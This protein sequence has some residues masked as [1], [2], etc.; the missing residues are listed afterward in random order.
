M[1]Q[2][3]ITTT[4]SL[5]RRKVIV[6][7]D[8]MSMDKEDY[9]LLQEIL[10]SSE[11]DCMDIIIRELDAIGYDVSVNYD[12]KSVSEGYIYASGSTMLLQAHY[13]TVRKDQVIKVKR[14]GNII[15]NPDGILGADDRAGVYAMLKIVKECHLRGI[16]KPGV[17][18]TGGEESGGIGMITFLEDIMLKGNAQIL[19]EIKR[20]RLLV[21]LDRKGAN[22]YVCY[23]DP[24]T[25]VRE[26]AEA[27][28]WH[29]NHGTFSDCELFSN[30]FKTPHINCSVGYYNQHTRNE[31]LVLDE[32]NLCINRVIS[33]LQH[34]IPKKYK[35]KRNIDWSSFKS[36]TTKFSFRDENKITKYG[37]EK[38]VYDD[39]YCL[40]DHCKF[41]GEELNHNGYCPGCGTF[42]LN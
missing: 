42:G 17:L 31:Y 32:L 35:V 5:P 37:K 7:I 12:E 14:N 29:G 10:E 15:Y 6:N 25:E 28:G 24:P 11:V 13:D 21:A 8:E 27:F 4:C 1:T 36:S 19:E 30:E 18:F 2:P 3:S 38:W 9:D 33:M 20:Y 26:Y 23:N 22:E 40:D 41:C 16:K 34:P 39:L